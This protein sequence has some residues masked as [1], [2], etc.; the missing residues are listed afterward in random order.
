MSQSFWITKIDIRVNKIIQKN[1]TVR[2]KVL[3]FSSWSQSILFEGMEKL[4]QGSA[5]QNRG[6][7]VFKN[8]P[9]RIR[10]E[11][12]WNY[13]ELLYTWKENEPFIVMCRKIIPLGN[14]TKKFWQ[15]YVIRSL[16]DGI[17]KLK[18]K[19]SSQFLSYIT[20]NILR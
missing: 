3:E 17:L 13:F 1:L 6:P 7:F 16:E 4:A 20:L 11:K 8:F 10:T 18:Q 14:I 2:Q 15:I 9:G 19:C 5:D 12:L